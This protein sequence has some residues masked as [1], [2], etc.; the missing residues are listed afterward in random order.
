MSK[1][2]QFESVFKSATKEVFHFVPSTFE[3][4]C[5]VTDLQDYEHKQFVLQIRE[6]LEVLGE[7]DDIEW[8]D[9]DAEKSTDLGKLLEELEAFEP[10]LLCT[11]RNLHS[12]GW[13][14]PYSLGEHLHV[15]T[16]ATNI[17]ILV[18]P[19]PDQDFA[20]GLLQ[21]TKTVMAITDH[22]VGDESLINVAAHFTDKDGTLYLTHVEDQT[23]YEQYIDII[24]KIPELNTDTA[25]ETIHNQLLKEPN[26]YI[27]SC[28]EGLKSALVPLTVDSIV[29]VGDPLT[30]YQYFLAEHEVNLLVINTKDENQHAM[31]NLAYTLAVELRDIPLLML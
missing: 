23:M 22:L 31:Q 7:P 4:V 2:D 26:D 18:L 6:F 1:I 14:W 13:Q 3:K 25:R 19:R 15:F 5:V 10:D 12:K 21:H 28:R 20:E 9:F 8:L 30:T 24:S 11:Y 16:Q 17:P 27:E 29:A